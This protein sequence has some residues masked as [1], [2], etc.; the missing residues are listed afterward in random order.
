[1]KL[2]NDVLILVANQFRVLAEPLRLQILQY[3]EDGERSVNEI[4]EA[5]SASQPNISKHLRV[6]HE[7]G[8]LDRRQE[9]NS[10]FYSVADQSIFTMCETVCG[11]L[12]TKTERQARI[13]A[14]A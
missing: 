6:M 5:T 12:K 7:A 3:L 8:I 9:K 11:S 1:M 4:V 10:A 14:A 2:S 13:M